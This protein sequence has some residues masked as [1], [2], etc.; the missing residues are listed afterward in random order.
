MNRAR[1]VGLALLLSAAAASAQD[2]FPGRGR[3][4]FLLVDTDYLLCAPCSAWLED[5]ARLLPPPARAA[6][7]R[8]IVTYRDPEG[9]GAG[10]RR[11]QIAR[12]QWRG[13]AGGRSLDLPVAFDDGRAFHELV[14]SGPAA[15]LLDFELGTVRKIPSPLRAGEVAE[16]AAFLLR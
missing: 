3:T 2:A 14:T 9:E 7:L 4:V 10:G 8:V 1:A 12:L 11:G 13:F 16:I 5:L 15:W 6:G